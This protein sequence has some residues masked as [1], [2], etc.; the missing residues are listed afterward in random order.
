VERPPRDISTGRH[1]RKDD[2]PPRRDEDAG[3]GERG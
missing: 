1:R 2:T 3:D